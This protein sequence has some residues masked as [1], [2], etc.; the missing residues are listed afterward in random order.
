M[1]E[2]TGCVEACCEELKRIT[3]NGNALDLIESLYH[4]QT[5]HDSINGMLDEAIGKLGALEK[6][7]SPGT[8]HCR[9]D[10]ALK[11]AAI[12]KIKV[13]HT[14]EKLPHDE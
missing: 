11:A 7:W 4:L 3:T 14:L 12:Y 9:K 5:A 10:G 1:F 6:L 8:F 2:F 13:G